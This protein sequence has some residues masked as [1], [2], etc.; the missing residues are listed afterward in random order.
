MWKYRRTFT[1]CGVLAFALSSAGCAGTAM[2][3]ANKPGS[4]FAAPTE[5]GPIKKLAA[6]LGSSL[7]QVGQ[8]LRGLGKTSPSPPPDP[9]SLDTKVE[10]PDAPFYVALARL[11]EQAN[12]PPAAIDMYQR[13]LKLDPKHLPA[14]LGLAR[15]YDR[16]GQ[17]EKACEL[18]Q[19]A[20]KDHPNEP[21]VYNDLGLCLARQGRL[22]E[23]STAVAK[24]VALRPSQALYRNNL[25]SMLV[26][27]GR[28]DEAY[29]QL[30]AVHGPAV[31]H[32]N[33]GYMLQRRGN[34]SLAIQQ[35]E[36]A[37]AAD[38]SLEAAQQW[39]AALQGQD[40]HQQIARA[41][42]AARRDWPASD[43]TAPG[44]DGTPSYDAPLTGS[45]P[46]PP[47]PE[48]YLHEPVQSDWPPVDLPDDKAADEFGAAPQRY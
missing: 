1:T 46:A 5:Q 40:G 10:P 6:S 22:P 3:V 24:A 31:A 45:E 19:Q 4:A 36:L 11:R 33:L 14:Q 15:L 42:H 26:E 13:A 29:S 41:S 16:Q 25:A 34:T 23:A 17:L 2:P 28:I 43:T 12:Q 44:P 7:D 8:S 20:A 27:Q 39:L 30:E 18:Y 32:Y 48:D 37:L 38:P 47:T 9:I 35:F 21:T